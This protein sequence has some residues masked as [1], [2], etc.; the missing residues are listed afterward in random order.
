MD[1]TKTRYELKDKKRPKVMLKFLLSVFKQKNKIMHWTELKNIDIV[2][3]E[4]NKINTF[5]KRIDRFGLGIPGEDTL[6]KGELRMLL[7][8]EIHK[9]RASSCLHCER[10]DHIS[11]KNK[12]LG[13]IKIKKSLFSKE[14]IKLRN[15]CN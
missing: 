7:V 2:T 13:T 5:E 3:K 6:L 8:K 11:L 12:L 9:I 4:S 14:K 10:C 15:V 1:V